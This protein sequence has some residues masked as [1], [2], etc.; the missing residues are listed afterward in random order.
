[1]WRRPRRWVAAKLPG[2][3]SKKPV[4]LCPYRSNTVVQMSLQAQL[5]GLVQAFNPS[6]ALK[7]LLFRLVA[8]MV[9]RMHTRIVLTEIKHYAER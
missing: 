4:S 5:R 9:P 7:T 2:S 8:F 3:L 1:M 6:D